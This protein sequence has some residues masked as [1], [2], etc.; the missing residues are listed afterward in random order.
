MNDQFLPGPSDGEMDDQESRL[1]LGVA[2]AVAICFAL[3]TIFGFGAERRAPVA[4]TPATETSVP[5]D[6]T[7]S[8]RQ[9][10]TATTAVVLPNRANF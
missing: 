1:M 7:N 10:T 5:H 2:G 4:S 3:A 6:A 9:A 8:P